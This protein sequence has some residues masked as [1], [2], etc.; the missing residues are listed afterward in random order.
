MD[1]VLNKVESDLIETYWQNL[2][3]MSKKARLSL[4][5]RLTESVAMEETGFPVTSTVKRKVRRRTTN[6]VSDSELE[7]RF[8]GTQV[9]VLP[10]G[11]A[12]WSDIVRANA[13]KT[14]K[15]IEKWL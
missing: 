7:K 3:S 6:S 15:P 13:G 8:A 2:C 1:I 14:I 11:D 5:S 4:A 9:P 12:K 10:A